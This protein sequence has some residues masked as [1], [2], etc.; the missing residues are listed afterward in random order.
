[1]CNKLEE[2]REFM[3]DPFPE[4]FGDKWDTLTPREKQ[5]IKLDVLTDKDQSQ[6]QLVLGIVRSTYRNHKNRARWKL[7]IVQD[8][9]QIK[10]LYHREILKKLNEILDET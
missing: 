10:H 4:M 2:L 1:M 7:G 3:G 8:R 5:V 9:G 6:N